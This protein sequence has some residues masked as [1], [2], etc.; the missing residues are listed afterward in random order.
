MVES[1]REPSCGDQSFPRQLMAPAL[2]ASK[3]QAQAS[4]L[5][6]FSR[7]SGANTRLRDSRAARPVQHLARL[8][9]GALA[10]FGQVHFEAWSKHLVGCNSAQHLHI[11]S[12]RQSGY[13]HASAG[14]TLF[15]TA[16]GSMINLTS[17][18]TVMALT[19]FCYHNKRLN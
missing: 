7:R 17:A 10:R 13:S 8:L 15:D 18:W 9:N 12:R 6:N 2:N 16:Q 5:F 14:E 3:K 1:S 11:L 19:P 4:I